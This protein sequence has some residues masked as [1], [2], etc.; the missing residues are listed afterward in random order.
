MLTVRDVQRPVIQAVLRFGAEVG[1]GIYL[2]D[3]TLSPR[4]T[5]WFCGSSE[6][7]SQFISLLNSKSIHVFAFSR[8]KPRRLNP[9]SSDARH[10]IAFQRYLDQGFIVHGAGSGVQIEFCSYDSLT[11]TWKAQR[12]GIESEAN[13][14]YLAT[15][16][17]TDFLGFRM[18]TLANAIAIKHQC[19]PFRCVDLVYTWVDGSDPSWLER[20][21]NEQERLE[22]L[23]VTRDALDSTRFDSMQELLYAIRSAIRYFV[24][25]GSIYVVTD[26]QVPTFLGELLNRIKLIDHRDIFPSREFLPC[27]NSHAIEA[28]LHRIP[29]L[30]EY[31]LYLN[32]DIFFGR[33]VSSAD[34]FDE[35]GRS[36][37]FISNAAS[38]PGQC[39][40]CGEL[41]VNNA[42]INNRK[43]LDKKIGVFAFRKFKHA[44]FATMRSLMEQMEED[45]SEAWL[46]TLPNKFRSP[47]DYSIAGALYQQYAAAKGKAIPSDIHYAYFNT[48]SVRSLKRASV[49]LADDWTRPTVFC[50]NDTFTSPESDNVKR[51]LVDILSRSIP[52]S[53][54]VISRED[55]DFRRQSSAYNK[56]VAAK[57]AKSGL[58]L[59]RFFATR[60]MKRFRRPVH[61]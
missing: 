50:I 27:F 34:F 31:Y 17:E 58:K 3:T 10:A 52:E 14:D 61:K 37:Q 15:L 36:R 59:I 47:D 53:S 6:Q 1:A 54:G 13:D 41:A 22:I 16:E 8:G 12:A 2:A 55:V 23:S 40:S 42:G 28:N 56:G 5:L 18:P 43:I 25:L 7:R 51:S 46:S 20:K 24:D 38:L 11:S 30:S 9:D 39:N 29:C 32:D 57:L 45:F 44:P 19:E 26:R 21:R 4:P 60:L 48:A 35:Y 33:A 49:L